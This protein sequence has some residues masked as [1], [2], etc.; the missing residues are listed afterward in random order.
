MIAIDFDPDAIS[1]ARKYNS[2]PNIRYELADI[3]RGIPDGPFDNV[4]WDA[5]IEHFTEAEIKF[6][7]IRLR[8]S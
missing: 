6:I 4:V 7:L 1:R 2:A 3:R 5:A 8:G